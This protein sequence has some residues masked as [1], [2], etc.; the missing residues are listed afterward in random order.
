MELGKG[1]SAVNGWRRHISTAT[2]SRNLRRGNPY[3]VSEKQ[4]SRVSL[5][6]LG[7]GQIK[8]QTRNSGR[9]TY[10]KQPK[11]RSVLFRRSLSP[12]KKLPVLS[13]SLWL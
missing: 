6:E 7:G 5:L 2:H 12:F 8:R 9:A 4:A 1:V 10:Q 13:C 3:W 11:N